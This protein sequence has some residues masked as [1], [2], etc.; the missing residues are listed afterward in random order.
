M[1]SEKKHSFI[2]TGPREADTEPDFTAFATGSAPLPRFFDYGVNAEGKICGVFANGEIGADRNVR[3]VPKGVGVYALGGAVGIYGE[4][5]TG[6]GVGIKGAGRQRWPRRGV[7][8]IPRASTKTSPGETSEETASN[9][10]CRRF[11]C[12]PGF[13]RSGQPLVLHARHSGHEAGLL[14]ACC[15]RP[16]IWCVHLIRRHRAMHRRDPRW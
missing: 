15:L 6:R 9:W 1:A 8:F 7:Q 10:R 4:A 13:Q 3:A 16:D 11:A 2:A 5:L 14:A 12:D